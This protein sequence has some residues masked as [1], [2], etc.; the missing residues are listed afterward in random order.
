VIEVIV[1]REVRPLP[2]VDDGSGGARIGH[3]AAEVGE[4]LAAPQDVSVDIDADLG[5]TRAHAAAQA[6]CDSS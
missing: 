6:R 5:R 3:V 2:L 1:V 4:D